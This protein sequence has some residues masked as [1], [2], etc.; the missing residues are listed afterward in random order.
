MMKRINFSEQSPS[1]V[2]TCQRHSRK[3]VTTVEFSLVIMVFLMLVLGMLE[4]SIAVF[5]LN[6]VSQAARQGARQGIVRG[7]TANVLG[8]WDPGVMGDPY[9]ATLSDNSAIP[10]L[11]RNYTPGLF[12]NQTT[13]SISWPDGNNDIDSHIRYRVS[14]VHQP[15]VTLLFTS[16]WT[17]V[18]ESTMPI[19]H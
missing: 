19:H 8:V 2:K 1:S 3:G 10:N 16:N 14:T 15:F 6:V 17:F 4:L 13:I 9:T 18:G 5:Q 11:L 7:R 12:E